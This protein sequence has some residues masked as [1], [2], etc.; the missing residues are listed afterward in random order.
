MLQTQGSIP[1]TTEEEEKKI[2][3]IFKMR[4]VLIGPGRGLSLQ[5]TPQLE[6]GTWEDE[7]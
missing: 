7:S 1:N 4:T 2:S 3:V 6:A 5:L